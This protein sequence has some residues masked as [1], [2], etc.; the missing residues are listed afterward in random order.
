MAIDGD[1][2]F[3]VSTDRTGLVK[4][5]LV[6]GARERIDLQDARSLALDSVVKHQEVTVAEPRSAMGGLK[7]IA[8][9][10]PDQRTA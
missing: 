6:T 3:V 9:P 1:S 2:G 8:A 4:I 5:S 10:L 7:F